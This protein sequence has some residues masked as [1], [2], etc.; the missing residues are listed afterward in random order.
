MDADD[1]P[2]PYRRYAKPIP[3]D[4]VCLVAPLT[5]NE[6]GITKDVIVRHLYGGEP[7]LEQPMGSATPRHTRYIAGLDVEVP[8]PPAPVEEYE[9]TP[10]DTKEEL[11]EIQSYMPSLLTYPMPASIIDELRNKYSKFRTR[12][13][14]EYV[15]KKLREAAR[16][17]W[18][19][20]RRLLTPSTEAVVQRV[21]RGAK[22]REAMKEPDG[23][24][25]LSDK[26]Q[27]YIAHFLMA[28]ERQ[29]A[30]EQSAQSRRTARL[31]TP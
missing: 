24:Y 23:S 21:Q 18:Q 22:E 5:D 11:V 28:K 29:Q 3:I 26:T 15:A 13:D 8:W 30:R 31:A 10:Y 19:K 25:K 14:T 16:E 4:D 6:T 27:N 7:F 2:R 1:D 12:H 17:E 20:S 9:T